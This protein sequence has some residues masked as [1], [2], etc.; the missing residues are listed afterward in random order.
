L[1]KTKDERHPHADLP[2]CRAQ[3]HPE[4]K[5]FLR[6]QIRATDSG[7]LTR[8]IDKDKQ[9]FVGQVQPVEAT[10]TYGN[11]IREKVVNMPPL[12]LSPTRI[13]WGLISMAPLSEDQGSLPRCLS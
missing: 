6:S 13:P 1:M 5:G 7:Y 9:R 3:N 8:Q 11:P 2:R 10:Y 4:P 12:N